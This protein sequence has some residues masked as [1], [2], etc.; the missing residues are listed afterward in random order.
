MAPAAPA[1]RWSTLVRV[2]VSAG[3]VAVFVARVDRAALAAVLG[4]A[5]WGWF[6]AA[7]A[8]YAVGQVANGL[9]WRAL[10]AGH[11]IRVGVGEMIRHDLSSVFWSA[12]VPGGVAGEVVKGVRIAREAGRGGTVAASIVAAR[13]CGG[14][15]AGAAGLALLP[16]STA[17]Q[18]HPVAVAAVL[19]VPLLAG[20]A[21]LG[22]LRLGPAAIGRVAPALARRLPDAPPPPLPSLARAGAATFA[23]HVAFAAMFAACFAATGHPV[24]L[25]DG[26]WISVVG[27]LAQALPITVGGLGVRELVVSGLG[28]LLVPGD[29][30]AAAALLVTAA[31]F[32]FVALG[33]LVELHRAVRSAPRA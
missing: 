25:A 26:A 20:I 31:F 21:G 8:A 6:G 33:G 32:G 7:L 15:M 3:L 18:R 30:A 22:V 12:V 13:L 4:G 16:W 9:G 28:D 29:A 2:V 17:A 5:R 27:S 24:G 14:A 10:L 11:G 19:A 1:R 23:A